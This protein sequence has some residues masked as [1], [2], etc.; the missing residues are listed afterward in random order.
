MA[1]AACYGARRFQ[2]VV[3]SQLCFEECYPLV[4]LY[5]SEP[6]PLEYQPDLVRLFGR[7]SL[8]LGEYFRSNNLCNGRS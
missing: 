4:N 7:K 2:V 6:F 8:R 1:D 5:F 3:A